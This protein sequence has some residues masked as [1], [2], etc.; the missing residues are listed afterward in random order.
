[1]LYLLYDHLYG[2]QNLFCIRH[3]SRALCCHPGLEYSGQL[4]DLTNILWEMLYLILN[5]LGVLIFYCNFIVIHRYR[6]I[7]CLVLL[8]SVR[9]YELVF[10]SRHLYVRIVNVITLMP[11][12]LSSIQT[13]LVELYIIEVSLLGNC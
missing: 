8:F 12:L 2:C 11:I 7:F 4:R 9:I 10:E 1:M 13:L 6:L 5:H 3:R